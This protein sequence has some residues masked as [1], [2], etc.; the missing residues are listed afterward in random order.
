MSD[1]NQVAVEETLLDLDNMGD[2]SFDSIPEAPSFVIPP[3]GVY[4]L[5]V[6]K[7]CIET[8]ATKEQE[9]KQRISHYYSIA[10]VLELSNPSEQAPSIG[11]KFSE[12]F[13]ANEDGLKYWKAKA[14]AILGD[15]GKITVKTALAELSSGGY[16]FKARV[17]VKTT[18][19]KGDNKGKTYQNIQVRVLKDNKDAAPAVNTDTDI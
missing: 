1:E 19:G 7:A 15:V 13:Q 12:R 16:T 5:S 11:D 18:A 6:T 2:L 17:Q 9:N 14:K 3:D 10:E 8:Y 4:M